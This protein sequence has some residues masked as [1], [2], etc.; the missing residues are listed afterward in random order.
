MHD[1]ICPR[2]HTA[3]KI[4]ES[5]NADILKQVR[6]SEFDQQ[7]H[8]RMALA[9][10]EK[11]SVLEIERVKAGSA[12]LKAAAAKDAEI[13][14][15]KAQLESSQLARQLAITQAVIAVERQQD[16]NAGTTRL[17]DASTILR[18]IHP[19]EEHGLSP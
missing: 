13:T 2:C 8:D 5:S 9:E 7:L 12:L 18:S 11:L 10:K 16:L 14:A 3:F 15:L 17:P 4:D 6:D 1:I 19:L